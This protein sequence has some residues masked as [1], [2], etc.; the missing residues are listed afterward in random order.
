MKVE[1]EVETDG[2]HES[3]PRDGGHELEA[4]IGVPGAFVTAQLLT[5]GMLG[6]KQVEGSGELVANAV[7]PVSVWQHLT[8]GVRGGG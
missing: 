4:P 7:K 8:D 1:G 6:T 3:F 2:T 5:I